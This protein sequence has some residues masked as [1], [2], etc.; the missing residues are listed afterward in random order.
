MVMNIPDFVKE[1]VFVVLEVDDQQMVLYSIDKK[2]NA[3]LVQ[4][5]GN[6]L[7]KSGLYFDSPDIFHCLKIIQNSAVHRNDGELQVNPGQDFPDSGRRLPGGNR[8]EH[9]IMKKAVQFH[10]RIAGKLPVFA[11]ENVIDA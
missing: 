9:A 5:I 4:K 11:E 6:E 7:D 3:L 8:E 1:Q 2:G 10:F